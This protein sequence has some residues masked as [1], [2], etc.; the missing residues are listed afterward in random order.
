[1][2]ER[3]PQ[4][5]PIDQLK[6]NAS[7]LESSITNVCT[8]M[9]NAGR[10]FD[11]SPDT[12]ADFIEEVRDALLR[13]A[14]DR[15][16]NHDEEDVVGLSDLQTAF[17]NAVEKF[18]EKNKAD[19]E[20]EED[21]TSLTLYL[22]EIRA[23]TINGDVTEEAM[24]QEHADDWFDQKVDRTFE[25]LKSS[26]EFLEPTLRLVKSIFDHCVHEAECDTEN[27]EDAWDTFSADAL[28]YFENKQDFFAALTDAEAHSNLYE[29]LVSSIEKNQE[30]SGDPQDDEAFFKSWEKYMG[31]DEGSQY[32]NLILK[33]EVDDRIDDAAMAGLAKDSLNLSSIENMKLQVKAN[34]R[35]I[36]MKR[37]EEESLDRTVHSITTNWVS[38]KVSL[39]LEQYIGDHIQELS[40]RNENKKEFELFLRRLLPH[41][42]PKWDK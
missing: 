35:N 20:K 3:I 41:M 18:V 24:A 15:L 17:D 14:R 26:A 5:N 1:M 40:D 34:L 4:Q 12:E 19:M 33:I 27:M 31:K 10:R 9:A 28:E 36:I 30:L 38:P 6:Q 21:L 11:I 8:K 22:N 25:K 2:S 37:V 29:F 32:L 7:M 16:A 23:I 39:L 13:T 42:H